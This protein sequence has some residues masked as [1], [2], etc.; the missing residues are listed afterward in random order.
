MRLRPLFTTV[1]LMLALAIVIVAVLVAT[2]GGA[3]DHPAATS[4]SL[5]PAVTSPYDFTEADT[6]VDFTKFRDAKFISLTLETPAGP[7]SYLLARSSAGF[8]TLTAALAT[9]T[10]V[11]AT[12]SGT[13]TGSDTTAGSV[14]A[15]GPAT[16]AGPP[17][18]TTPDEI[19]PSLTVV[20]ADRT[21]FT[22]AL[23]VAAGL[24]VR[25]RRAWKLEGDLKTLL[26]TV[27][28]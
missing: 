22:F 10:E 27:S 8:D 2:R 13:A 3:P 7:K 11:T 21:T 23:D 26:E 20:M 15:G 16:M 18:G 5:A 4:T 19:P 6:P 25:N 28:E 1:G 17:S 12:G 9:A 14:G 24:M